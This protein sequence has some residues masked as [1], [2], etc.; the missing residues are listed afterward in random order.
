MELIGIMAHV[1]PQCLAGNINLIAQ[2]TLLY[3]SV[4]HYYYPFPIIM[5]SV[6]RDMASAS[7]TQFLQLPLY[8]KPKKIL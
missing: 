2:N 6:K 3:S 5:Y 8:K 4:C 1:Q 7:S